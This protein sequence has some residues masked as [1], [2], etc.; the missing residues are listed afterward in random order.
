MC[1]AYDHS[2]FWSLQARF[3]EGTCS[4]I[5]C[6]NKWISLISSVVRQLE[7]SSRSCSWLSI[8]ITSFKAARFQ[9]WCRLCLQGNYAQHT[10]KLDGSFESFMQESSIEGPISSTSGTRKDYHADPKL[11]CLVGHQP[12][13]YGRFQLNWEERLFFIISTSHLCCLYLPGASV[14]T[15]YT[16]GVCL[17]CMGP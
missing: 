3:W 13:G 9:R 5:V 1:T 12:R 14:L 15:W 7:A 2:S 8:H 6:K 4:N 17:P 11:A 16:W 10:S